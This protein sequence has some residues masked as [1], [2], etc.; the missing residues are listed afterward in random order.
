MNKKTIKLAVSVVS[1]ILLILGA[2]VVADYFELFGTKVETKLEFSEVRF[3]TL[4]AETGGLIMG[5][6][7]RC[8]QKNNKNACTRR[9]SHQVGVVT[10]HIPVQR[11]IKKTILFKKEEGIFKATDPKIHIMFIHQD[12]HKSTETIIMENVYSNNLIEQTVK[13]QPIAWPEP[14]QEE[15]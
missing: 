10:V 1:S 12:H 15:E 4:D 6:G 9:D 3:R 2:F 7:V 14:E 8:F 5:V 11:A 13:M